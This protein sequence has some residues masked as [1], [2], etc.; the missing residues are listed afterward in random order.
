MNSFIDIKLPTYKCH[1]EIPFIFSLASHGLL[2]LFIFSAHKMYEKRSFIVVDDVEF[3]EMVEAVKPKTT[4]DLFKMAIPKI[5]RQEPALKSEEKVE[6]LKDKE[7]PLKKQEL[8][9][10]K[11]EE[12][13]EDKILDLTKLE[14]QAPKVK[15]LSSEEILI[16]KDRPIIKSEDMVPLL[17]MEEVGEEAVSQKVLDLLQQIESKKNV[18]KDKNFLPDEKLIE[19][20]IN[21]IERRL[22]QS[23]AQP[24]VVLSEKTFDKI[25]LVDVPKVREKSSREGVLFLAEAPAIKE[26]KTHMRGGTTRFNVADV[27]VED[28]PKIQESNIELKKEIRPAQYSF[29][30]KTNMAGADKS[31]ILDEKKREKKE[32]FEITGPL[33]NRKIEK[34]CLPPYPEWARD[35]GIEANVCLFFLVSPEGRVRENSIKVE[36][37][38]GYDKLDKLVVEAIKMWAFLSLA[39]DAEQTDQWGYATFRYRLE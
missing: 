4:F 32:K 20:G 22:R 8:F 13:L 7:A 21:N 6:L 37:T 10:V 34:I 26:E 11:K 5:V 31:T 39:R 16:E 36:M 27:R 23:S 18:A 19:K 14:K 25:K 3:M 1:S 30:S 38:S 9:N 12:K 29:L 33:K 2:F 17:N 24:V 15:E 28:K 35:E